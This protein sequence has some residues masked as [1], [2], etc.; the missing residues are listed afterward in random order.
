MELENDFLVSFPPHTGFPFDMR[1]KSMKSICIPEENVFK[2]KLLLKW[3]TGKR[4]ES[5]EK[6]L[7]QLGQAK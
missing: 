7:L 2:I 1:T 3:D 6:Y 5:S 4:G